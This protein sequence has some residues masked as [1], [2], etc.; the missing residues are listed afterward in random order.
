[1]W[2]CIFDTVTGKGV[3]FNRPALT[4]EFAVEIEPR[5]CGD[6]A[7]V[8]GRYQ[9]IEGAFSERPGWAAESNVGKITTAVQSKLAQVAEEKDRRQNDLF[10]AQ[11]YD[12]YADQE[13]TET[14]RTTLLM[15][16]SDGLAGTDPVPTPA[17]FEGLWLTASVDED[18]DRVAIP[19]TV[20][21][22]KLLSKALYNRNARLWAKSKGHAIAIVSMAKAG[23]TPAQIAA[24]DHTANW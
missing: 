22:L 9:Y 19:L 7:N 12:F 18:G 23:A 15:A 10:T 24:Y 21:Q 4:G 17:P 20:A 3:A 8:P 1:M 2:K 13:A 14:I 5:L 16:M 6:F 11:G